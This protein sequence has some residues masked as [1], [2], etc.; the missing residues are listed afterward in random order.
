MHES[1]KEDAAKEEAKVERT[2]PALIYFTLLHLTRKRFT[3]AIARISVGITLCPSPL[4]KATPLSVGMTLC[5][6][7]RSLHLLGARQLTNACVSR[8]NSTLVSS[9][10]QY[11]PR[12]EYSTASGPGDGCTRQDGPRRRR[13]PGPQVTGEEF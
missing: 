9:P 10:S 7:I 3:R 8:Y 5:P 11:K 2:A 4:D 12:S 6:D 1:A 13:R